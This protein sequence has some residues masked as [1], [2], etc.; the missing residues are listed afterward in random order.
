MKI[1]LVLSG[2]GIM[3]A[4]FLLSELLLGGLGPLAQQH[5]HLVIPAVVIVVVLLLQQRT[6]RTERDRRLAATRT[7]VDIPEE[8]APAPDAADINA[9]V[10]F[11]LALNVC[12]DAE[13]LGRALAQEL[14]RLIGPHRFWVR[15]RA[16][17][18]EIR[19]A[20][21]GDPDMV[22]EAPEAWDTF[23]LVAGG[24]TIGVLGIQQDP[25]PLTGK[26]RETLELAAL[27]LAVSVRNV[28][29]FQRLNQYSIFDPLTGCLTR[30]QGVEMFK[31]EMRRSDR[32]KTALSVIKLDV[33]H[34]P[35]LNAHYG[36]EV[37]DQ[38]LARLGVLFRQEFRA[39]DLRCRYAGGEFAFMLPDTGIQGAL[40]A[41]RDLRLK[42][43]QLTITAQKEAVPVTATIGVAEVMPTDTDPR[44]CLDRAEKALQKAISEGRNRVAGAEVR[45]SRG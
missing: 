44:D 23:P 30:Q 45:A 9:Q 33:D 5:G 39:S 6:Q 20:G 35:A 14:P 41:A 4:V 21:P 15:T 22:P 16:G 10:R 2:V 7:P 36:K 43:A 13:A 18:P 26:Q 27:T 29:L 3:A 24:R 1:A 12:T 28:Q 25:G 17:G 19:I 8:G 11:S 37:G 40:Q 34:L 38:L 31:A 32:A 42:I